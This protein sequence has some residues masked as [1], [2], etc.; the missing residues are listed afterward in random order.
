M[1][2]T[3]PIWYSYIASKDG[4]NIVGYEINGRC[5]ELT[6]IDVPINTTLVTVEQWCRKQNTKT[7]E[8][9]KS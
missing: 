1:K 2:Y 4:Y 3:G 9:L 5:A 8:Y 6:D 7:I